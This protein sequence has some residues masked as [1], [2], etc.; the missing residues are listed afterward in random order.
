MTKTVHIVDIIKYLSIAL[1][2]IYILHEGLK[3]LVLLMVLLGKST[4]LKETS[5]TG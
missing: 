4:I 2:K 3:R 1:I 5:H